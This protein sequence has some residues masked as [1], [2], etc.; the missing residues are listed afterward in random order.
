MPSMF[1]P[2]A[3]VPVEAE[4]AYRCGDFRRLRR[5][6]HLLLSE[7]ATSPNSETLTCIRR[8][9]WLP[10]QAAVVVGLFVLSV[11]FIAQLL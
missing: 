9:L 6:Y 5:L 7:A 10:A 1:P 4:R 2:P 11:A 3:Q 8:R